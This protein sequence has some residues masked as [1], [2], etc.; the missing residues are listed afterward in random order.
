MP[1][2]NL[3]FSLVEARVGL[4]VLASERLLKQAGA[5]VLK[6]GFRWWCQEEKEW[7]WG[8]QIAVED[9]ERRWI[10]KQ[11]ADPVVLPASFY[12]FRLMLAHVMR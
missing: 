12:S 9:P 7:S 1:G 10:R 2:R 3:E 4:G 11:K 8:Q 5:C 6:P